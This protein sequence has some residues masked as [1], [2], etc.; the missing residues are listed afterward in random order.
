MAANTS[1]IFSI[2]GNVSWGAATLTTAT[3]DY[4]G[5][6]A[7]NKLV[8]TADATNGSF[9]QRIRLKPIGTNI[10]SVVRFYINNGS[11]NGTASNNTFYGEVSLP[12]TT[13]SNTAALIEIDYP[14]NFVLPAGYKIYAGVATTVAAGWVA[15][16]V[17][18]N[19]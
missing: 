10:A 8:F 12:A 7:N 9:L 17:G 1:P 14:F 4:D 11:T 15:T 2:S 6:G 19:Y 16:A 18:G 3:G 5:T 13:A